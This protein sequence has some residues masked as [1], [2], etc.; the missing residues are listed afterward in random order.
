[1]K[2]VLFVCYGSGHVLM[3]VP[4]AKAL[5][6]AGLAQVQVLGLTTAASVVR[7]AGLPLLQFKDFVEPG[8]EASL[9]RG[10]ELAAA[11]GPLDDPAESQA[12]LGLCYAELEADVGVEEARRRYAELARQA[13][14]P[15]RALQRILR[16]VQPDLVVATNSPRA[17]RAAVLAAGQLGIPAVCVV[18]LFAVDE[19]RWIGASDYGQKVCVLNDGVREFLLAAGRRPDQVVITGNPAFDALLDPAIVRQGV[20]LR[21]SRGWNDRRVLLWPTQTE[22]AVH[23]FGGTPGDPRLP[24]RVLGRVCDWVSSNKDAILCVRPRAGEAAPALPRND[25]IIVTGQDWSLPVLLHAVDTVVTL[26]STVG[27]E[28]HL[29]GAR[30]VQVLGSAF[31]D[32]MPLARFGIADAAVPEEHLTPALDHWTRQPRTAGSTRPQAATPRVVEVL[33]EFL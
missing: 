26:T 3:V 11:M 1:M 22:P 32:A 31:D 29:C 15:V 23:P 2:K 27:L 8:D 17:E 13:F 6:A 12:Y 20:E 30:L 25:R 5:Q 24:D 10:R 33:S 9:A 28:G 7:A 14:L 21:A 16:Q 19:V 4:V 18:D